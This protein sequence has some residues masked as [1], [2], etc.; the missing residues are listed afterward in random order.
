MTYRAYQEAERYEF[1]DEEEWE[2]E[3]YP[4]DCIECIDDEEEQ[5]EPVKEWGGDEYPVDSID[6]TR[7]RDKNGR[8]LKS[9]MKVKF[10]GD[11]KTTDRHYTMVSEMRRAVRKGSIVDITVLAPD[12]ISAVGCSWH[13]IDCIAIVEDEKI[14]QPKPVTFDPNF[15]DI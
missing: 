11:C 1:D 3:P 14:E 4:E 13:P 10:V 9:G 15:L 12:L 6:R 7:A 5:L 2:D 8:P